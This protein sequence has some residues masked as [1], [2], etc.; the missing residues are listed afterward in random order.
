[1]NFTSPALP[2]TSTQRCRTETTKYIVDIARPSDPS[3]Q[4]QL[5]MLERT[6]PCRIVVCPRGIGAYKG[7]QS[8]RLSSVQFDHSKLSGGP[9]ED[10]IE[11][12][13]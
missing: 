12:V 7:P 11:F 13:C 5:P 3:T 1:M 8:V 2:F 6:R 9:T 10:P 4:R